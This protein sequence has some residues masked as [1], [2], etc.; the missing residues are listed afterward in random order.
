MRL[1]D[2]MRDAERIEAAHKRLT[3]R[4]SDRPNRN[5][6]NPTYETVPHM[7]WGN[8][9]NNAADKPTPME[10]GTIQLGKLTAAEREQC[11]KVDASAVA[12]KGTLR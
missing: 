3:T 4:N 1:S 11:I 6:T 7:G 9:E 8:T 2:A 5:E 12:R 10:I